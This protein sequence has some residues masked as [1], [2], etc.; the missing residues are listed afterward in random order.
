MRGGLEALETNSPALAS[1]GPDA[2]ERFAK[3]IADFDSDP[4]MSIHRLMRRIN[5][6]VSK[7]IPSPQHE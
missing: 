4:T 1:L 7:K 6:E 3:V 2:Q 5:Q